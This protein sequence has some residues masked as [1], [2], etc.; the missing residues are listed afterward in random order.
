M[1]RERSNVELLASSISSLGSASIT[2]L[3]VIVLITVG[4][5]FRGFLVPDVATIAYVTM[6]DP[7]PVLELIC[8]L[9][10]TRIDQYK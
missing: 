9:Y 10:I 1:N 8:E 2:G 5:Y 6:P 4:T 7:L 3:Y